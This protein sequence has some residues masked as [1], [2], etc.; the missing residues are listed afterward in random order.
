M[1]HTLTE[2]YMVGIDDRVGSIAT[3][4]LADLIVLENNLFDVDAFEIASTPIH[5]TMMNGRITHRDG[6]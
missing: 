1:A 3:G 4:K 6:L 2:A 5:L